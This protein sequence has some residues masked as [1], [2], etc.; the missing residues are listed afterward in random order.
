[1]N[2]HQSKT[3]LFSRMKL[4]YQ[5]YVMLIPVIVYFIVF[6]YLPMMG[7][8]IAFQK[9]KVF[10]GI[11][12]SDWIGFENFISFLSGRLAIPVIR[13][14][15]TI[16]VLSLL[17]SFPV[18]ILFALMLNEVVHPKLK[19]TI[20]TITYLPHFISMVVVVS[21]LV[22]ILSPTYGIVGSIFKRMGKDPIFFMGEAKYFRTLYI[23]SGIWQ[24]TGWGSI[25]YLA[26]ISS[27]DPS[28]YEA[29]AIDGASRFKQTIHVTLPCIASTIVI[30][31]ILRLG[32]LL[33]VGFEKIFLMQNS[34]NKSVSEVLSTYVYQRGIISNDFGYATAVGFFNSVIS[35][36]LVVSANTLCRRL[37]RSSLW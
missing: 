33:D 31:F 5:L 35:L 11:W 27:I 17:F 28:L 21:M 2:N 18:P 22:A 24:G 26:A 20:Q 29:A 25:I 32:N 14:T 37:T 23:G 15:I 3:K 10:G 9:Y 7:L 6:K 8:V 19:R 1:M 12:K 30:M 16:N 13:N 4:H 34:S 36:V